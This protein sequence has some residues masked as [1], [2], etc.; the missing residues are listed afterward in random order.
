LETNDLALNPQW[1]ERISA[2]GRAN[3][4]R[5]EMLRLGFISK[6]SE[7]R[8]LELQRFLDETYPR[9]RELKRELASVRKQME[10]IEDLEGLLRE[11]RKRRIERVRS[12]REARKAAKSQE[13]A[14]RRAAW[15][16]Q[17]TRLPPFLGVGVSSRLTFA[18]G[19]PEKLAALGLPIIENVE[20]LA[21]LTELSAR[22]IL[23]LSYERAA[24]SVDHYT[25]FEIPKR[26]GGR[27]LIA[28]PKPKLRVAQSWISETVLA[29]L[30]PS[31][32]A[33]AFRPGTSIVQNASAHLNAA[34]VIRLDIKD[35]YP[36][37]HFRRVRGYFEQL[38]FN[39][40]VS[41]V[42]GLLCTDAPRA[43]VT[44]DGRVQYVAL[45]E[46]AL[47]QG[48]CTSP[49]LAN[50]IAS[51]LD[52]R[53]AALACAIS[54]NWRYTRYADDMVFSSADATADVGR[55]L[56]SVRTIASDEGFALNEK[57]T[58]VMR[59]PNRQ[60]VTGLL[61]GERVRL[62]RND[63]RR[64][65]AF[66]HRCAREGVKAVSGKI[67][68]DALAVARGHLAYVRMVMPLYAAKL[69]HENTWL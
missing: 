67:N 63:V 18:G 10:N 50:L 33:T 23:W 62:S 26:S 64:L 32:H 54:G 29:V 51:R 40:G 52:A 17:M 25:R 22:D 39:P 7:E 24:S 47:P 27:R 48:A 58:A 9:I 12:E 36:S 68:K 11:V 41:T 60:I 61:V 14:E 5:E 4:V 43:K 34:I 59:A 28:S 30:A 53:L 20:D 6:L 16:E 69:R 49:G 45:G 65:R 19:H 56:C 13:Q 55:L 31:R 15:A 21:R 3:F 42:L 37:I 8:R 44:L 38:G 2:I 57:K 35:F 1:R 46:R 66:L